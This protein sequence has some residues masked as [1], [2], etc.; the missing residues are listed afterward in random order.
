MKKLA[1]VIFLGTL[2]LLSA[3]Q[4]NAQSLEILSPANNETL[5]DPTVR[6]TFQAKDFTIGDYGEPH[7]LMYL[8]DDPVPNHFYAGPT[9]T[10]EDGVLQ[11]SKHNH[12]IHWISNNSV[13]VFDFDQGT[14]KITFYLTDSDGKQIEST[15]K[16]LTVNLNLP[17]INDNIEFET[18]KSG[19]ETF[20]AMAFAPDGRIYITERDSG[21]LKSFNR[22]WQDEKLIT[23]FDKKPEDYGLLGVVVDPNYSS[24]KDIYA[25]FSKDGENRV[26][27]INT[28]SK[29]RTPIITGM[30][31]GEI[32]NAGN[33][34][35]GPD[36]KLYVSTGDVKL[37][38]LSQQENSLAGKILRYNKDGSVPSDNPWGTN[39]P[40]WAKGLRNPFDFVFH[41]DPSYNLIYNTE[42]GVDS[43]DEINLIKR[44]GDYG[45]GGNTGYDTCTQQTTPFY[46]HESIVS[47]T[48]ITMLGEDNHNYPSSWNFNVFYATYVGKEIRR[49]KTKDNYEK[50]DIN[51]AIA[52]GGQIGGSPHDLEL[53]LDGYMYVGLP[54]QIKRL[55]VKN[56][57]P[58]ITPTDV[59]IPSTDPTDP[60]AATETP[61]ATEPPKAKEDIAPTNG[62]GNIDK[63]DFDAFTNMFKSATSILDFNGDNKVNIYDFAQLIEKI[64]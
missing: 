39:N 9:R 38:E 55:K 60:P 36:G 21:K 22:N 41:S 15:K 18:V 50:V 63:Q 31:Q 1:T 37:C 58:N 20:V 12:Q 42:N 27:K 33:M 4:I 19:L 46:N 6:I 28:T 5:T 53:G 51:E 14:N 34:R 54:S 13:D 29:Q 25:Y 35:F 32:H 40:A 45:W 47:P 44:G 64:I 24:N 3:K 57:N 16:E 59:P 52:S 48:G 17:S 10:S 7:M 61:A 23:T 49:I 11:N 8:K 43:D 56:F 62:D 2:L 26:E 30:P